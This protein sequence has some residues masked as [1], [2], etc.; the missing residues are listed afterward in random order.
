[1]DFNIVAF[2]LQSPHSELLVLAKF[3]TLSLELNDK[4]T[5]TWDREKSVRPRA[6]FELEGLNP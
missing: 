1:V 3:F 2:I 4:R 5:T 6:S